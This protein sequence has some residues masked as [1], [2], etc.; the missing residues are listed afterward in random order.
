MKKLQCELCNGTDFTKDGDYFVCD[1]CR[2][3]YS[4]QQAQKMIIEGTV[5]VAGTVQVD[6]RSETAKSSCSPSPRS[7]GPTLTRH[8]PTRTEH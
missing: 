7:T 3:K 8:T 2:A 4:T 6:R 1:Y 5:E